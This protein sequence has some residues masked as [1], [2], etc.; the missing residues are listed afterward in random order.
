MEDA[1]QR[2]E[3]DGYCVLR[4]LFKA[5]QIQRALDLTRGWLT[6]TAGRVTK[7][8]PAMAK[9]PIVWNLQ[10]KDIYFLRLLF[11]PAV[12]ET[13]LVHFLND[14][15]Y[16]QIPRGQPNYIL[17]GYVARS[18]LTPLPLHIDSFVPYRGD[19]VISMQCAIVLESMQREH[20]GTLVV[21]GSHRSGAYVE[22]AALKDAVAIE[23][24]AGDV[25]VWDSRLWHGAAPN[26]SAQTRWT[27]I[28]TFTRWWI[29]QAFD[30]PANLP[31]AIYEQ[32]L[33]SQK[34]I[35]GFCSIPHA[36]EF[37]G[38]MTQQ[39]YD[40]LPASVPDGRRHRR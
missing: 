10:N 24:D 30:I 1:I 6:E 25:V 19:H 15:W 7:D 13:I 4:Q 29:K 18:G 31:A 20:G 34:A 38:V 2:I 21:P 36:D 26:A 32:L 9:D 37:E 33:P 8:L 5:E 17:R 14:T 35:L 27:L 40:A 23:A 28:A 16:R 39:G 22:Q 11:E 3:R 12:L